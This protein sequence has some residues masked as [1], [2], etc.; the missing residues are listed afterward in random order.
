MNFWDAVS[1]VLTVVLVAW[2]VFLI[3]F[4]GAALVTGNIN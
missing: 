2:V 4:V 3:V 1:A